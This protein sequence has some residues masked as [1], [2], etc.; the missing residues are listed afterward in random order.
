MS[1]ARFGVVL[2]TMGTRPA[3]LKAAVESVLAQ[4]NVV[5]DIVV[6]GNGWNPTNLPANVKTVHLPENLGIPD[7][8][9]AGVDEVGGP[10]LFF[11]DDD[12]SLPDPD[13]LARS[14][15]FMDRHANVGMFQPRIADPT[16]KPAPRRWTPRL[17][18]TDPTVSGPVTA[19]VETAVIVRRDIFLATGG[20]APGFFYAHEGIDLAWRVWETGSTV[21]YAGD[22][23]ASHPVVDPRRHEG[24]IVLDARNRV[25]LARRNLP[26]PLVPVYVAVWSAIS[27]MRRRGDDRRAWWKGFR[28]GWQQAPVDRRPMHWKT[29]WRMT[30]EGHRPPII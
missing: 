28:Q 25:W 4:R 18:D 6:V 7:G 20:W 17:G 8:R 27:T 11:M 9:N 15:D 12:S 22:L 3:E 21:W 5:T 14:A 29:V 13:F 24:G 1:P 23:V 19:I 2:L 26:G 30:K 10:L 16:G